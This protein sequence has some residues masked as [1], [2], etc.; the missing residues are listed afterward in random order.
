M[1]KQP[2]DRYRFGILVSDKNLSRVLEAYE[3]HVKSHNETRSFNALWD[4]L[5]DK[6]FNDAL[7]A[8][9]V[10]ID[11]FFPSEMREF[12]HRIELFGYDK[13]QRPESVY[14][15]LEQVGYDRQKRRFVRNWL[16]LIES[17]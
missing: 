16:E 15:A 4:R 14:K 11:A 8:E 6:E 3:F 17:Q 12:D 1:P 2:F 7:K 5:L 10:W 13:I 9:G